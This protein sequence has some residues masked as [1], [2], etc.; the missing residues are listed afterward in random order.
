[1]ND[2]VRRSLGLL[3]LVAATACGADREEIP[4]A[5]SSDGSTEEVLARAAYFDLGNEYVPP[6]GEALHHQTAGFAKILCSGVFITGLDPDDAAANVGGFISP[7]DERRHVVDTVVDFQRQMVSLTLPDG[8][9]RTAKRYGSQGCV[10][11]PIGEDSISYAP[12]VVEPDLPP[13]ETTPWPM[14]DALS[15]QPFPADVDMDLIRQAVDVI[16]GGGLIAYPTDTTYALGCGIGEKDALDRLIRLRRLDN[17][18]QFTLLC[19]DLSVLATYAKVDNPDYRLLKAHAPG[20][21]TFILSATSEV[22]RRLMHPKKRTIGIR[23]PDHPICQALLNEHGG[24][25]MTSTAH[26]PDDEFPLTDPQDVRDFLQG[27]VDLVI[28][29]G[30]C[31]VTETTVISLADGNG[32]EVVREGAGPLDAI[33]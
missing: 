21:Y 27:Q 3:T 19:P 18:H 7:F 11:H 5:P 33:F 9:T 15:N 24:P 31:G 6:P 1:M 17:K 2:H 4:A 29:G 25:I 14:G 20:P 26:L 30:F 16:R 28:D 8:V 12:S 32:P 23:V 10:P 13:A 22:P